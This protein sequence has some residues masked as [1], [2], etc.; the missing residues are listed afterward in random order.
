MQL[1]NIGKEKMV[2]CKFI[3]TFQTSL[4]RHPLYKKLLRVS[5]VFV[6]QIAA[7][8]L[9]KSETMILYISWYRL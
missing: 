3:I 9:S 1:S 2:C 4:E 5:S 6:T 8:N 7:P